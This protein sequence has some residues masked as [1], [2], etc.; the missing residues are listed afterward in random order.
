[1]F[2]L[3]F[4]PILPPSPLLPIGHETT[5][6]SQIPKW[7]QDKAPTQPPTSIQQKWAAPGST[8][9]P[10]RNKESKQR[11]SCPSREGLKRGMPFIKMQGREI[12]AHIQSKASLGLAR[13]NRRNTTHGHASIR[14]QSTSPNCTRGTTVYPTHQ[15]PK[16]SSQPRTYHQP[17]TPETTAAA[18]QCCSPEG[19]GGS[20]AHRY[21]TRQPEPCKCQSQ[22]HLKTVQLPF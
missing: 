17:Q 15:S 12:Q 19:W 9:R 1:M 14:T 4:L 18:T 6:A 13:S 8:S 3:C 5:Q 7:K 11:V 2:A 10:D 16:P 20:S 22:W 21:S